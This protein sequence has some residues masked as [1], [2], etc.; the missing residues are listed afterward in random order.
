MRIGVIQIGQVAD[1]QR[2]QA[3]LVAAIEFAGFFWCDGPQTGDGLCLALIELV[4]LALSAGLLGGGKN[5]AITRA[6][7]QI[8]GQRFV[9]L[10]GVGF[11]AVLLQREQRHDKTGCAET[12]L[13]TVTLDHGFLHAVQLALML[14]VFD[15]DQLF[16]V[17]RGDERQAG[18]E[19]AITQVLGAIVI[20]AQFADHHGAGATIAAGTALFGTGL[21]Q[22]LAQIIEHGQIGVQGVLGAQH[23]IE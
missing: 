15:A 5:R 3:A 2:Y 12:T 20:G 1:S 21:T 23:L 4:W 19:A 18:I 13:R 7:A 9:R 14:E 6:A 10:M 22:M 8:A 16:A 17:Q 11:V